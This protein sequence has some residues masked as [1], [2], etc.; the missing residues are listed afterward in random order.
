[1]KQARRAHPPREIWLFRRAVLG[2][3]AMIGRNVAVPAT[4][5]FCRQNV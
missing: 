3:A 4:L 1:M 5:A 2:A